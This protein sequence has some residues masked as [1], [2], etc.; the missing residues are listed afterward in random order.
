M[1]TVVFLTRVGS[2]PGSQTPAVKKEEGE[3]PTTPVKKEEEEEGECKDSKN[4][5]G[6]SELVK[7]L[8]NQLK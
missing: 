6:D 4:G 3:I 5:R 7:D 2:T 1:I 8:R